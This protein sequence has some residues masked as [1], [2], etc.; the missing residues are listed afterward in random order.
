MCRSKILIN[1]QNWIWT[2]Y[3]DSKLNHLQEK[4]NKFNNSFSN[5][6]VYLSKFLI[7]TMN[8]FGRTFVLY[9]LKLSAGNGYHNVI[10][11]FSLTWEENERKTEKRVNVAPESRSSSVTL[12]F[13][14]GA[15][16]KELPLLLH[17]RHFRLLA[18][19]RGEIRY[20]NNF[21]TVC[22]LN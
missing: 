4:F 19:N 10:A 2:R 14:L 9:L 22:D 21:S 3:F 5:Y 15:W 17:R 12:R 20:V 18:E 7:C 13:D 6:F 8:L 16:H 11:L 1:T